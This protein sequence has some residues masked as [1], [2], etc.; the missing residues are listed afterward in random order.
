MTGIDDILASGAAFVAKAIAPI[1]A[2]ADEAEA[3]P[4][5]AFRQMGTFGLYGTHYPAR[6]GGCGLDYTTYI[7][8]IR[9]VAKA[10]AAT[11]MTALSHATLA[12]DPIFAGG[13]EELKRRLLPPLIAGE[14]IGAFAMTESESGSDISSIRTKAE[15]TDEGY[16][17]NG[18]KL[19]IT[20]ANIADVAVVVAKT[21][22]AASALG[23]SLFVIEKGTPGFHASGRRERKLGMRASDTGELIF[24]DS[25]VPKQN[26]LGRK[27]RGFDILQRTL[28]TARLGMAAIAMGITE[29]V[30]DL[31]VDHVLR[32]RQFGKPLYRFQLIQRMLADMEMNISAADLLLNKATRLRDEG[33]SFF[34]E[35]AE[36]KL[37]A[38][39]AAVAATRDAIQIHGAQ[40]Y[41]RDLPLER[42]F[43]DA[44]LTE[45]GDGTSEIQRLIIADEMIKARTRRAQGLN[46]SSRADPG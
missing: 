2:A 20:N 18:A 39:E 45:I 3:F 33:K 40:G 7:G 5:D 15:E 22:D 43:R 31:C 10:C 41:C 1:A 30:R 23:L 12:C 6:Y 27:N 38:S 14:K 13:N 37:F 35:A 8:L 16:V 44:K 19:F 46:G 11:A 28:P 32:R 17:L 36:A 25:P 4:L 34:K 42:F 9:E 21:S 24:R 29:R 26:L